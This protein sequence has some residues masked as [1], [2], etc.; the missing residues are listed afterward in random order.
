MP[1]PW[2]GCRRRGVVRCRPVPLAMALLVVC[3]GCGSAGT[4]AP[5]PKGHAGDPVAFQVVR[6]GWHVGIVVDRVDLSAAAPALAAAF[7]GADRLE[8]GWGDDRFYQT[9]EP[10]VGL[11]LRAALWPTPAVLHVV[12]F[13]G[14]PARYFP[15]SEVVAVCV[16]KAGYD[17]LLGFLADT[18][19]PGPDGSPVPL[20]PGL[21]GNSRFFEAKGAFHLFHTCNTWAARAVSAAGLPVSSRWTITA[22]GLM[23]RLRRAVAGASPCGPGRGAGVPVRPQPREAS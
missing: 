13:S 21:Y 2:K 12:G 1:I 8:L 6:H 18:I 14:P 9:P 7:P 20:G 23:S 10:S 11:A 5:D 3:S 19:A 16:E 22:G 17:R 4:P 15:G